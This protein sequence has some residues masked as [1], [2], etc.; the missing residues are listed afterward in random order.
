MGDD[1]PSVNALKYG[2]YTL[3]FFFDILHFL[4][5]DKCLFLESNFGFIYPCRM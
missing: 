5:S 2:A 1:K 4:S 3:F